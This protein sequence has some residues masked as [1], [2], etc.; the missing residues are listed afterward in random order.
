M[1]NIQ[2]LTIC[3]ESER[4]LLTNSKRP[5]GQ[6]MEHGKSRM[7]R[8]SSELLT[9]ELISTLNGYHSLYCVVLITV[10]FS[11][12]VKKIFVYLD[13]LNYERLFVFI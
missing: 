6:L 1:Q 3:T 7:Y 5:K 8:I 11:F 12:V 9:L 2:V 4:L 13:V 10:L